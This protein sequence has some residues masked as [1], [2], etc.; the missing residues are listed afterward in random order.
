CCLKLGVLSRYVL[1]R[2]DFLMSNTL[3]NMS[4][5][6]SESVCAGHPDK[7]CDAISDAIVDA[8][9]AQDPHSRTAIETVAGVN[10]I[11]LFGEIK[12]KAKLDYEQIARDKVRDLGYIVPA[13]GFSFQ[14]SIFSNDIHEQSPE[15]SMGVDDGGAGDQGMMFGYACTDTP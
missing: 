6:T 11:C 9:L 15:I 14:E 10:Q 7:I 13:W 2:K 8:A 4:I 3:D 12:T 5:F 1:A